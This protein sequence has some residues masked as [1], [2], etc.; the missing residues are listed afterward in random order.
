MQFS[1]FIQDGVVEE[2]F[3]SMDEAEK[4]VI[5]LEKEEPGKSEESEAVPVLTSDNIKKMKVMELSCSSP[6]WDNLPSGHQRNPLLGLFG[7]VHVLGSKIL[8]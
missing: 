7:K 4:T 1:P 3:V 6:R 5:E 8:F 2:E